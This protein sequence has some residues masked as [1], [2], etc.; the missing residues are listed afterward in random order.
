VAPAR[1]QLSVRQDAAEALRARFL[2]RLEMQVQPR[3]GATLQ[4][5][6]PQ[7]PDAVAQ[8]W[9]GPESGLRARLLGLPAPA[10]GP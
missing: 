1:A 9:L 7:T 10:G 2:A 5:Q 8:G 6:R 4:A 3:Q